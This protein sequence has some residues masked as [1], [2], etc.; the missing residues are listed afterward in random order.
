[1]ADAAAFS[2]KMGELQKLRVTIVI[3]LSQENSKL[4]SRRQRV[5]GKEIEVMCAERDL[6][7]SGHAALQQKLLDAAYSEDAALRQALTETEAEIAKLEAMMAKV[8]LDIAALC[9]S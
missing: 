7:E 1:M 6:E 4:L 2:G 3:L 8:D 5:A 9:Q